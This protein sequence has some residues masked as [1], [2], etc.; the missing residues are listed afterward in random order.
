MDFVS[1]IIVAGGSGTRMNAD[2]RKQYLKLGNLPIISRTILA[3][4]ACPSV[5]HIYLVIPKNDCIFCKNSILSPLRLRSKIDIV[6]AGKIRQ[7]S[8]FNGLSAIDQQDGIVL[9]HDGVR[10]FITVDMVNQ[11]IEGAKEYGAC[12][13]GVPISDT[14]KFSDDFGMILKTVDRNFMW[15]A[16]TPQAF[17]FGLIKKAHDFAVSKDFVGT[18]DASLL[19]FIGERVKIIPGSISNIKITTPEDLSMAQALI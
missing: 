18:D 10:P 16:Q 15:L 14:L 1:A 6:P 19:E 17:Q 3:I 11:C 4:D 13:L 12:I 5:A 7:E 9:I 8:V 2:V